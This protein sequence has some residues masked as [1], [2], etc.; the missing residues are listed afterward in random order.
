MGP[1]ITDEDR[2][3]AREQVGPYDPDIIYFPP[4]E[5]A[6]EL[7]ARYVAKRRIYNEKLR[8]R[9]ARARARKKIKQAVKTFLSI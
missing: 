1:F 4:Y 5:E 3:K 2:K 8:A 6:I 9:R 7:R